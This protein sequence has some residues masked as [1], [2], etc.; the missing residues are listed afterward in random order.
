MPQ[1]PYDKQ[2]TALLVIDPFNDFI[3]RAERSGI[4]SR[5]LQRQMSAFPICW[6]S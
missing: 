6:K 3:P 2:I 1:V 4:A 5:P